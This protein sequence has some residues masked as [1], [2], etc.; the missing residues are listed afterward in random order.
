[1]RQKQLA[2]NMIRF[3]FSPKNLPV[4]H[5]KMLR[6]FTDLPPGKYIVDV[7]LGKKTLSTTIEKTD[8]LLKIGSFSINL[9]DLERIIKN[10]RLIYVVEQNSLSP[11]SSNFSGLLFQLVLFERCK[12]PTLEISGI[13]MHRVVMDP[14]FHDAKIKVSI[15]NPRPYARVLE[16]CTGLGYTTYWLLKR[17]CNVIATIEKNEVV[18]KIA[19]YNPWSAHLTKTPIIVGAAEDLL[20]YFENSSIDFIL[21]DPPRIS[22]APELYSTDVYNEFWRILKPGGRIFHYTGEPGKRRGKKIIKGIL[23]RLRSAGFSGVAY[24]H[25]A[26]GVIARKPKYVTI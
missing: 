12:T 15:L 13:H 18:L 24:I 7:S 20:R 23:E 4:F 19:E 5:G 10:T 6:R 8:N 16:V 3:N 14:L 1:M 2:S 21:H 25:K 9:N 11:I 26:Q 17:K 22:L